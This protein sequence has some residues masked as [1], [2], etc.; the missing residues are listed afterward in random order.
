MFEK[1]KN[2]WQLKST[3]Q[4]ILVLLTFTC[5]GISVAYLSRQSIKWLNWNWNDHFCYVLL[6]KIG[7][8]LI[9]Y[10]ILLLF[11]GTI[12]G[13]FKFFWK[14]EKKLWFWIC[15]IKPNT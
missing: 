7:I 3:A 12:F 13:Q 2:R 1:L 10:Q 8:F 11:F 15:Q 4:I 5:T 9:G 14:Y 6:T